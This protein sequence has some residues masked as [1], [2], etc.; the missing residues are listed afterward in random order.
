MALAR[1]TSKGQATIPKAIRDKLGVAPGDALN[2]EFET[3][4]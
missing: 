2:F 3:T 4:A 1:I